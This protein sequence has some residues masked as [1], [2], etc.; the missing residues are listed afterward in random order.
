MTL[1]LCMQ[2][3]L[4]EESL[5][6][7]A[8][9]AYM[10]ASWYAPCSNPTQSPADVNT[11]ASEPCSENNSH[12]EHPA[13]V[14]VTGHTSMPHVMPG[15]IFTLSWTLIES[16]SSVTSMHPLLASPD[17]APRRTLVEMTLLPCAT[18]ESRSTISPMWG[19]HGELFS[20]KGQL[21]DWSRA[22][23]ASG[24]R[25]IPS[26]LSVS[27]LVADWSAAG[28]GVTDDTQARQ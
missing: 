23:Y 15:H 18:A 16:C 27:D 28:D 4:L 7:L 9:K 13:Q 21:R 5:V 3:E 2:R 26:P 24:D 14:T 12:G 11:L 6:L 8:Q 19:T 17:L 20:A 25:P 10:P 1:L 22:G